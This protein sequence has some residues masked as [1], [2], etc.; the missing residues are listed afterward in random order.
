VAL[1]EHLKGCKVAVRGARYLI[2]VR[3]GHSKYY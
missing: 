3:W 2:R 1:V